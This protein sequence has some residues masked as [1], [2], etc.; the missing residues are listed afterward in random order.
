MSSQ[1]LVMLTPINFVSDWSRFMVI[2]NGFAIILAEQ[3][4]WGYHLLAN[5]PYESHTPPGPLEQGPLTPHTQGPCVSPA[6][7]YGY[8]ERSCGSPWESDVI[9][10]L[11]WSHENEKTL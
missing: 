5:F 4:E 11:S 9:I 3:P 2:F 1:R 8:L 7:S 10:K 6:Q